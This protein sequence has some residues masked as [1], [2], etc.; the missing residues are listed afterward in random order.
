MRIAMLMMIA[1]GT[2]IG[3]ALPTAMRSPAPAPATPAVAVPT[4]TPA[5]PRETVIRREDDGHF[6]A[7]ANV[8]SEPIR[9]VVDTGA[10]TVAL[11]PEDARRA[12]INFDPSQVVRVG[13][14][15]GGELSGQPVMIDRMELD[16]KRAGSVPAVVLPNLTV[17]L[18]GQSYLRQIATVSIS[19]DEM[20][21][22]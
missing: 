10:S 7:F 12:H 22:K 20:R 17:S 8:N 14:S 3:L 1:L 5:P 4:A 2:V 6:Y 21:L 13:F 11:T 19:N 16:G 9:F 18:L 15:A